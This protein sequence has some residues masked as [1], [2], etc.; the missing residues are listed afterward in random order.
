[1]AKGR[2]FIHIVLTLDILL[3]S[4]ALLFI[5]K[6]KEGSV[7]KQKNIHNSLLTNTLVKEKFL[8][9]KEKKVLMNGTGS[10]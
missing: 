1:M 4:L 8:K 2:S 5:Q 10:S 7:Y 6:N 3:S 9:F